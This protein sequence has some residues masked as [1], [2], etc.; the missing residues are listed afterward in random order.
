MYCT[1]Q[2][3]KYAPA[4]GIICRRSWELIRCLS[5]TFTGAHGSDVANSLDGAYLG[6]FISE[7]HGFYPISSC[8]FNI[9]IN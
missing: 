1:L 9:D 7:K 6:Q 3:L 4:A 5:M 2:G 8:N